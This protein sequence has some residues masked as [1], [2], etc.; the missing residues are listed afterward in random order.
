MIAW[1]THVQTYLA[2]NVVFAGDME[3]GRQL[4][5]PLV[6]ANPTMHNIRTVRWKD[7]T[8]NAFFG[9]APKDAP[10]AKQALH[11]VYSVGIKTYDI[12][13]FQRFMTSLNSFYAAYP[14]AQNT[15]FFIEAFPRQAVQRVPFDATSY[16]HRDIVAHL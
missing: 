7:L 6:N 5:R 10:C 9:T 15:V 3:K 11:N 4:V 12:P 2:V 14:A 1:L 16:P 8:Y 13:T